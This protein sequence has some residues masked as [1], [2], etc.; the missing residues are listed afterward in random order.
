MR[1]SRLQ[2]LIEACANT[3]AGFG[4]SVAGGYVIYPLFGVTFNL[5]E[6]SIITLFFTLISI[7]RGY[8]VRR[9]FEWRLQRE[10]R[11]PKTPKGR[12]K[13]AMLRLRP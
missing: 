12:Q 5:G 2:S 4:L 10:R 3:C 13:A 1:Q 11:Q 8:I 6:L 7:L 9:L